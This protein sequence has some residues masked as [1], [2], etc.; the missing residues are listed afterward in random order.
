LAESSING[1]SFRFGEHVYRFHLGSDTQAPDPV[2]EM[3]EGAG[4]APAYRGLVYLTFDELPLRDFGNRIPNITAEVVAAGSTVHPNQHV[5]LGTQGVDEWGKNGWLVDPERPYIYNLW[6]AWL[7]KINRVSGEVVYR[8]RLDSSNPDILA[9]W[10]AQG[11]PGSPSLGGY[12]IDPSSGD[13]FVA[14][15]GTFARLD[16]DTVAPKSWYR[17][18]SYSVAQMLVLAGRYLVAISSLVSPLLVIDFGAAS[19]GPA[20]A[21]SIDLGQRGKDLALDPGRVRLY[22]LTRSLSGAQGWLAWLDATFELHGPWHLEDD[23]GFPARDQDAGGGAATPGHGALPRPRERLP[24]R[25][26][27]GVGDEESADLP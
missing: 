4:N 20:L 25:L 7:L 17:H 9:W 19:G 15:S 11:W 12:A 3:H 5:D 26:A 24:G 18:G 1:R 14:I 22:V 16:A 21:A 27:I 13:L 6:S 8:E 10:Q 2:I 23:L